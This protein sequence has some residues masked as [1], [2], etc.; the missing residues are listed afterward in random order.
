MDIQVAEDIVT[1]VCPETVVQWSGR[2]VES[3]TSSGS[4]HDGATAG[5]ELAR[6]EDLMPGTRVIGMVAG[7]AGTVV[8]SHGAAALT[9]TYRYDAGRPALGELFF[10]GES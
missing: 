2:P 3:L 5:G 9:L 10:R 6:L 4:P 1:R 7:Q 8:Q